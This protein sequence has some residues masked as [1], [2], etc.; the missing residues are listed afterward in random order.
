M[1]EVVASPKVELALSC[2]CLMIVLW[3]WLCCAVSMSYP[4]FAL[5][6]PYC[7]DLFALWWSRHWLALCCVVC[8]ILS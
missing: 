4:V 1:Y 8:R 5:C 7:L 2:V 6:L 3:L